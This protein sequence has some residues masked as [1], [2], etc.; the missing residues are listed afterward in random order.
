MIR[1]GNASHQMKTGWRVFWIIASVAVMTVI[2]IFSS[3][4]SGKSEDLSDAFAEVLHMEQK[5]ASTRVS[6]QRMFLGL[7]LRKLAHIILY[8]G[9]G[10]CLTNA[11][12]G[13]RGK[14]LWVVGLSYLY[15]VADELHQTMTG[16][17]GRWED[18][19]IDLLGIVIGI[20][21]AVILA[22]VW[23]RIRENG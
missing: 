8:T 7:T 14:Y 6:N 9:L 23:R 17:Y 15:A 3:Q 2:F 5:E 10:F 4:N 13:I 1:K 16:R 19:L 20:V 18:T 22:A 11:F 21:A 12:T